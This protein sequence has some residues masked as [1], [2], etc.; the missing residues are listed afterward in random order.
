[1]QNGSSF[2][3]ARAN[4]PS[5][6]GPRVP[7]RGLLHSHHAFYQTLDQLNHSL[8]NYFRAVLVGAWLELFTGEAGLFLPSKTAPQVHR[9][10][11]APGGTART[12]GQRHQLMPG[13]LWDV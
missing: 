9:P 1:M 7:P 8:P 6:A 10:D 11:G 13:V 5:P 12:H 2:Q 4:P 3:V